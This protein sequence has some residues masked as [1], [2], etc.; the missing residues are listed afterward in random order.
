M[1]WGAVPRRKP[2]NEVIKKN[3]DLYGECVAVVVVVVVVVG[4]GGGGGGS[5]GGGNCGCANLFTEHLLQWNFS[6]TDTLGPEKQFVIQRFPL[7]SVY[8]IHIAIYLGPQKQSVMERFSL[9]GELL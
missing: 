2:I 7:L 6:I 4:G 8:F 1:F 5:G 9:L 3:P